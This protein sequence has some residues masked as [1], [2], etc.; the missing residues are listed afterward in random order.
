MAA[1]IITLR[2]R[3]AVVAGDDDERIVHLPHLVE[4]VEKASERLVHLD[5]RREHPVIVRGCAL[6]MTSDRLSSSGAQG[7]C[8]SLSQR[9]TNQGLSE[10][11]EIGR[12]HV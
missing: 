4:P 2:R 5:Q 8:M 6:A 3:R 7:S 9:F 11:W 10:C 12:A 1:R